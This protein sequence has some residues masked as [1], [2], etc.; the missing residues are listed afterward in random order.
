MRVTWIFRLSD[1]EATKMTIYEAHP[2]SDCRLI[3]AQQGRG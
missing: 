1:R 2:L 3:I